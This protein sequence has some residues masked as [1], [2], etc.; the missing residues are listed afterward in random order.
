L[1]EEIQFDDLSDD[2]TRDLPAF[3]DFVRGLIRDSLSVEV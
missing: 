1:L 2:A 3:E